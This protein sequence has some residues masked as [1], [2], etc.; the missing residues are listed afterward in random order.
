M[1]HAK[2]CAPYPKPPC[3]VHEVNMWCPYCM[4]SSALEFS[5]KFS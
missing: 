3:V 1:V 4:M 2:C 5:T